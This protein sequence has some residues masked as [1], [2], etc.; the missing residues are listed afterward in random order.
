MTIH[1]PE[2]CKS[3]FVEWRWL[4]GIVGACLLGIGSLAWAGATIVAVNKTEHTEFAKQLNGVEE[5][6]KKLDTLIT[7]L[8][9]R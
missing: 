3:I 5:N 1:N 8:K 7:M 4:L 2:E 6:S 9:A